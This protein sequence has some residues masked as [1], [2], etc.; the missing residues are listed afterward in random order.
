[1]ASVWLSTTFLPLSSAGLTFAPVDT[2]MP[3]FWGKCGRHLELCVSLGTKTSLSLR[4]KW[5]IE[6]GSP[7][8]RV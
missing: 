8:K 2:Q 4:N 1:M 6:E 3:L 5:L 7:V